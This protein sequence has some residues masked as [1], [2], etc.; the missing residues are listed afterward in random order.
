[1][2]RLSLFVLA[3]L[4]SIQTFGWGATGHRVTGLIAEQY[5]NAKAKKRIKQLLGQESLAMV[6]TWMD[7]IRSDST[8]RYSEDWH[9][10]TIPDGGRYEDVENDPNL[11]GK[12]V[13]MIELF[14]RE[15]KSGKLTRDKEQE[16]LKMLVHMVGDIHQPLHVGRPGDRGGNQVRVKWAGADTN[17]HTVWDSKMIDD[18]HLSYTELAQS[19][20]RPDATVIKKWQAASVRDWAKESVDLRARVYDIGNGSLGYRYAYVNMPVVRQRLLQAGVRLAGLLNG[21]YGSK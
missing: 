16:Y 8:Y 4:L 13:K 6:S 10:T 2:K 21:I 18:T 19:L 15:L 5:L 1:M 20:I 9:W 12:V 14:T 11:D 3:V 17:L 7:E